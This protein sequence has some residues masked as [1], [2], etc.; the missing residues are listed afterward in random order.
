VAVT[1]SK[2]PMERAVFLGD[3]HEPFSD[4]AAVELA[5]RFTQWFKPDTVF[6]N[7]DILDCLQVSDYDRDPERL[8]GFQKDLDKGKQFLHRVRKAAPH[9]RITY[10]GGNHEDR[11]TRYLCRH[12]EISSL[13]SLRWQTL[14]GLDELGVEFFEYGKPQRWHGLIV[15]H[16]D[17]VSKHSGATA[18]SML[19]ARGVSG[20]SNHVHRMGVSYRSDYS[21]VK[22]WYENGCLCDLNPSYTKARPNWQHGFTVGYARSGHGRFLLEQI[23][24]LAGKLFFGDRL[25]EVS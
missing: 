12:P 7:G 11:L 8:T 4:P 6:L 13:N 3:V 17:R 9:A 10:L 5:V 14:L 16:G 18:R 2:V 19:E 15:E 1:C 21:G 20:I 25:W 22:A 23:P 24:I